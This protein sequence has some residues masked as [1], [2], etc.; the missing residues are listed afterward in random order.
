MPRRVQRLRNLQVLRAARVLASRDTTKAIKLIDQYLYQ[1]KKPRNLVD[2]LIMKGNLLDSM[3][4]F[5]RAVEVYRRVL[6]LDSQNVP[7]LID[8]GDYYANIKYDFRRALRFY[9]QA[10]RLARSGHHYFDRED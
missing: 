5:D 6:R 9:N 8:L 7:A 2:I 4:S 10:M 3:A 1:S